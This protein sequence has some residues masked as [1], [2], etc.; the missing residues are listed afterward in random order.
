VKVHRHPALRPGLRGLACLLVAILLAAQTGGLAVVT[1]D[2]VRSITDTKIDATSLLPA[3]PDD[4]ETPTPSNLSAPAVDALLPL[5]P[6]PLLDLAKVLP[7]DAT[8]RLTAVLTAARAQDVWIYVL[9]VPS[10]G[11]LPS[12]QREK[13]EN[14]AKHYAA[15]WTQESVGAVLIFDG[16]GG[17]MSVETS[18]EARRRFSDVALQI[19]V[20]EPLEKIHQEG[21]SRDKLE[22]SAQV[23]ADALGRLQTQYRIE[24]RRQRTTNLIMAGI[25]LLGLGLALWGATSGSKRNAV[26]RV[27]SEQTAKRRSHS[28]Y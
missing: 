14:L 17:L 1:E 3:P 9:T 18:P 26:K 8:A 19:G 16:E 23:M 27:A 6:G 11:V 12:R 13:L 5:P 2:P 24:K 22:R 25:A 15:A 28:A 4:S 7:L 21:L 10:L 20:K